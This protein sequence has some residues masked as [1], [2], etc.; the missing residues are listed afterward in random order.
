MGDALPDCVKFFHATTP[1][2][3]AK[4]PISILLYCIPTPIM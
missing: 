2:K 4:P 1:K 3:G